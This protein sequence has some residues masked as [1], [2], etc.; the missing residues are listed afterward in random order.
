MYELVERDA[1]E[2]ADASLVFESES[3]MRRVR[4]YPSIWRTLSDEELFA[5]S[6]SR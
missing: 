3:T 1:R 4:Q 5:L 2:R 6:W